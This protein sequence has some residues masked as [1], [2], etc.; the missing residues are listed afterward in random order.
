MRLI[1]T[2]KPTPS[3]VPGSDQIMTLVG[4]VYWVAIMACFAGL[5]LSGAYLAF[6]H[7]ASPK[8]KEKAQGMLKGAALGAILLGGAGVIFNFFFGA[9]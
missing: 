5:V 6:A 8:N 2:P 7:D 1:D 3:G 9:M 4:G